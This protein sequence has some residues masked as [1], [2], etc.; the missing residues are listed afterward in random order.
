[1]KRR[2]E[3]KWGRDWLGFVRGREMSGKGVRR[4]YRI[5]KI[6]VRSWELGVRIFERE[7]TGIG[8]ERT[9][10]GVGRGDRT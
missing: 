8:A 10:T 9:E 6:G 2:I 4:G 7:G 3:K 1:M 5:E